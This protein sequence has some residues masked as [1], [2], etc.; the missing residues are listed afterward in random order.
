MYVCKDP[1]PLF[2]TKVARAPIVVLTSKEP[3][4]H[5]VL[6]VFGVTRTQE[7]RARGPALVAGIPLIL[8]EKA[9]FLNLQRLLETSKIP[10]DSGQWRRV[11]WDSPCHPDHSGILR[12]L[13]CRHRNLIILE[14]PGSSG[15][16]LE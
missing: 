6:Q 14:L 7:L 5:K 11:S 16:V 1:R 2:A 4:E 13:P 15:I 12:G 10:G 8:K 9:G 3:T